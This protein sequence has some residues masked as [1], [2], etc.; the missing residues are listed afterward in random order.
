MEAI[1]ALQKELEATRLAYEMT[2]QISQFKSS[3][4][5]KTAH[6]LRSPLSSLMGLHQ[7]ILGNLCED[8]QEEKEFLQQGFEA[9]K[10]LVEIIDRIVTI[11]K[12]DCGKIPL[13]LETVSLHNIVK[14]V[15]Q[16][17]EF[18]AI[19][20]SYR[21]KVKQPETEI[22]IQADE[23]LLIQ[24]LTTLIDNSLT[25]MNKGTIFISSQFNE[26][27]NQ[28]KLLIDI[29]CSPQHWEKQ[30]EDLST[31]DLT[32]S[33]LKKWSHDLQLSPAMT[34]TLCQTLLEKMGGNLTVLDISP[35]NKPE[36]FTRLQCLMPLIQLP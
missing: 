15:Y 24:G 34:L 8:P 21:I 23:T 5:A 18:Q 10:K 25:L 28:A 3:Y 26:R 22:F 14:E 32:L 19:N 30:Q 17:T 31:S 20:Y 33:S 4:L 13:N 16:L 27:E 12:I 1:E 29:P 6:E 7:L 35:E 11:S 36:T 2:T 9:A